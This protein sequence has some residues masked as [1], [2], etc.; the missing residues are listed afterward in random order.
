M[1]AGKVMAAATIVAAILVAGAAAG[2][3][4]TV[5]QKER[6]KVAASA[7]RQVEGTWM[8]RVTLQSPPPGVDANFLA[9]N[10]FSRGGR[11]LV[12]S[13]QS[14]PALRSLAHGEWAWIANRRFASTMVWF[15]FDAAGKFVGL[16]RVR[17]ELTLAPD[18]NSFEA[19]DIVEVIAAD[20]TVVAT[21]RATESATR[22]GV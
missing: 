16:Q 3:T 7:I 6:P 2:S 9:L 20:G 14:L 18:L 10:T 15:R 1:F 17:R 11:L 5:T 19:T 12:S 21:L 22:L 13:S 4:P 8:S